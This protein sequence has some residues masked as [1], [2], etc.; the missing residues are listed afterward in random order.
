MGL[1]WFSPRT[2]D[3]AR[4]TPKMILAGTS[5]EL[6]RRRKPSRWYSLSSDGVGVAP[7]VA[8]SVLADGC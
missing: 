3:E 1:V 4:V 5:G 7:S 2:A 6:E 8:R